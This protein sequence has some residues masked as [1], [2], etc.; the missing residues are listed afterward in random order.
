LKILRTSTIAKELA[1]NFL[2]LFSI[3]LLTL[4]CTPN[5]LQAL[6]LGVF[7]LYKWSMNLLFISMTKNMSSLWWTRV[8]LKCLVSHHHHSPQKFEPHYGNVNY[9]LAPSSIAL[10]MPLILAMLSNIWSNISKPWWIN[11]KGMPQS[12]EFSS[13]QSHTYPSSC[14][15]CHAFASNYDALSKNVHLVIF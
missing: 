10:G 2:L 8:L 12:L 15:T 6:V 9:A 3:L 1:S 13:S 7:E 5:N 11:H 14:S 4:P